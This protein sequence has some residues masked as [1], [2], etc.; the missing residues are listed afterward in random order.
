MHKVGFQ[1]K[2]HLLPKIGGIEEYSDHK[3][4]PGIEWCFLVG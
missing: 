3:I 1:E 2:H 4:D